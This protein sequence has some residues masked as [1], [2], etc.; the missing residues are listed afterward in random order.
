M[1]NTSDLRHIQIKVGDDWVN[2]QLAQIEA[3]DVFRM[4]EPDGSP[5]VGD[6]G[7]TIEGH[8]EFVAA[9]AP[10]VIL[11]TIKDDTLLGLMASNKVVHDDDTPYPSLIE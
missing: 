6:K 10:T 7:F 1:L 3:G 11:G 5:V 2:A 8:T 9:D 4:F